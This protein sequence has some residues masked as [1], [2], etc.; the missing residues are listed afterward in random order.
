VTGKVVQDK[1]DEGPDEILMDIQKIQAEL[2]EVNQ[3]NL[4]MLNS[5]LRRAKDEIVR[6]E[7]RKKLGHA[8]NE[9][10]EC[11]RKMQECHQKKR[12]PTKK[13]KDSAFKAVAQRD[14]VVKQ[15]EKF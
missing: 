12:P 5:L 4:A 7:F 13:E 10:M 8:D 6:Q 15:M 14:Q 3:Q 1:G 11:Y 9:V 2:G